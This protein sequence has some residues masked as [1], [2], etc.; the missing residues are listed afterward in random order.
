[1]PYK[2]KEQAK[3]RRKE[4]QL[5]HAAEIKEYQDKYRLDNK[6]RLK[7]YQRA[8]YLINREPAL[9]K[10]REG[11]LLNRDDA[12]IKS[13]IRYLKNKEKSKRHSAA[14]VKANPDARK[15]ILVKYC[16][17]TLPPE[18]IPAV[19]L[20]NKIKSEIRNQTK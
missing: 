9:K 11:Y 10:A 19:V 1:M 13:K 5:A 8:W 7:I 2:D 4:Y 15:A 12:M 14:W 20:I 3:K 17:P 16:N 18:L 6:E